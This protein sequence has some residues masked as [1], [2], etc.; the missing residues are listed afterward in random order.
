MLRVF[1]EPLGDLA[2]TG[3][4]FGLIAAL[5]EVEVLLAGLGEVLEQVTS[6]PHPLRLARAAGTF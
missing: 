1:G 6:I 5:D 2:G 3:D 4:E